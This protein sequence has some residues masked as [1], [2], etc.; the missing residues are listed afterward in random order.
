IEHYWYSWTAPAPGGPTLKALPA[1]GIAAHRQSRPRPKSGPVRRSYRPARIVPILRPALP[2]EGVWQATGW[3]VRG[4]P[5]L[6]VTTFRPDPQYPR[7]VAYVAWLDHT[8]TQLGLY[9]GRYEPPGASPRGPMEVPT[10]QRY[11]L[12]ATFNSGFTY[13]D[14]HGGFAVDGQTVKPLQDGVG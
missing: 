7:V 12:L 4:E 10:G 14:G 9:P 13:N 5:P 2:G 1:V 8:R 11:R 6:Y 3:M